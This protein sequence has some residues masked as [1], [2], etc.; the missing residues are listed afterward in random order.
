MFVP[1]CLIV[2][3]LWEMVYDSLFS[4][5]QK[6]EWEHLSIDLLPHPDMFAHF[7]SF[8]EGSNRK[9]EDGAKRVFFGG[10]RFLEG[11]SG[12]AYVCTLSFQLIWTSLPSSGEWIF[13]FHCFARKHFSILK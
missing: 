12:E 7:S 8:Q 13:L 2:C 10:E 9:D 4:Y 6:L 1:C 11:I 3:I 5:P